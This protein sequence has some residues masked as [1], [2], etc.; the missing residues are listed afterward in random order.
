M[1][2]Q[3]PNARRASAG[4]ERT[5]PEST[6]KAAGAWIHQ[7]ARTLKVCRLYD[8][9]N[10]TVVRFRDE[11]GGAMLQL[12]AEHGSIPYQFGSDD[13]TID[14]VSLYPARSRDDNLAFPF[15]RDGVRALTL[16]AGADAREA[17]AIVDALLAVTGQNLDDDDLVTL[18]WEAN[19]H[20]IEV[21][22]V[23]AAGDV[24]GAPAPGD[25]SGPLLPWPTAVE[26]GTESGESG[27]REAAPDEGGNGGGRSDDWT[28]GELTAEVEA[29]FV[30]LDALAPTETERFCDEYAAEHGV[31]LVTAGL[32]IAHACLHAGVRPE[33]RAEIAL[34]FTRILRTALGAGA[35]ADARESLRLVRATPPADW[36]E[37]TFAQELLQPISITRLAEF[38]DQQ[39]PHEVLEFAALAREAGEP[40]VDWVTLALAESREARVRQSLAEALV[41]MCR[42]N[43]ERLA[44]WL[45][46]QRWYVVRNIVRI[47]GWI[48][49]P[50]IVGLLAVP[51][52]HPEPRV[53]TEVV[54]ALATV[55]LKLSR[56]LLVRA[57]DGADTAMFSRILHLLSGARDAS[58]GRFL[59]AFLQQERF[60]ERPVEERRAIYA[61]LASVGGDEIVPG[62][63][64]E[65]NRTAWIS[66][67]QEAHRMAVAR[68]L[69][70]IGT[71]LA[72]T[73]LKRGTQSRRVP[74]RAA[75]EAALASRGTT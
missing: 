6:I 35:W 12:V 68:C 10:P 14:G 13:V 42:E 36:S 40:G 37:E 5:L 46:D 28:T 57:L 53:R 4:G 30:E 41:D 50:S 48:G 54:E 18:L 45:S 51:L 33:D 38:L 21:D 56:S 19:L 1:N 29:C 2:V 55:D 34:L 47:L 23:P 70:C 32:A 74:V 49:G 63:D 67:S 65:L 25:E 43:P 73:A 20:H 61:A 22:V 31:D 75:C 64:A 16:H 39:A 69:A 8:R 7:L 71:A 58:T 24:G 66:P 26:S 3:T 52:R 17:L 62:L 9:A 15:Y 59:F 72:L 27:S 44:P 11:L 60:L